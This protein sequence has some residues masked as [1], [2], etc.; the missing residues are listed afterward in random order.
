MSTHALG[1]YPLGTAPQGALRGPSARSIVT[2]TSRATRAPRPSAVAHLTEAAPALRLRLTRRG[3]FVLTTTVALPLA[4]AIAMVVLNGGS[5]TATDQLSSAS[6][7][8]VQVESG[9]SLWTLAQSIAPNSDPRDVIS[10]L[11]RL[12]QLDTAV[13]QPGQRLAIPAQYAH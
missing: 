9:E 7:S 2:L 11:V 8:Y 13:V 5:A 10:D 12:N 4:T 6:F 3:R 1:I